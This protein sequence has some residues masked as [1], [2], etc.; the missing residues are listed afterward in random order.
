MIAIGGI[1]GLA[2]GIIDDTW[3]EDD[4]IGWLT[5]SR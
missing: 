5:I 1:V 2:K 3:D 4:W